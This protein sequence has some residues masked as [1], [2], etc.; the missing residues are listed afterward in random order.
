MRM[1]LPHF[2]YGT[3]VIMPALRAA[4]LV[5]AYAPIAHSTCKVHDAITQFRSVAD[6]PLEDEE[7]NGSFLKEILDEIS[8]GDDAMMEGL[9]EREFTVY[10]LICATRVS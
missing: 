3:E 6:V 2:R 8:A 1:P 5:V 10:M 4:G 9:P 7:R